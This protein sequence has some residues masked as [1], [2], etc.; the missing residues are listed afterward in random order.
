MGYEGGIIEI[1]ESCAVR[2][3][4]A[5]NPSTLRLIGD[6]DLNGRVADATQAFMV[7]G[8]SR[9]DDVVLILSNPKF[10]DMVDQAVSNAVAAKA[11][12][13]PVL[14]RTVCTPLATGRWG[15]RSYALYQRLEGFSGNGYLRGLQM[16]SAGP[17][18]FDWLSAAYWVTRTECWA[19][20]E[21]ERDFLVPLQRLA[22]DGD[23]DDMVRLSAARLEGLV[24]R[25]EVRTETCLQHGDFWFGNV[26]FYRAPIGALSQMYLEFQVIDWGGSRLRGYPGIDALR[27][28]LS[29]FGDGVLA[30]ERVR[31]F[32]KSIGFSKAEFSVS[33]F[34]GLGWLAGH[35]NEF[36][37][38]NFNGMARNLAGFLNRHG[39]LTGA[40][41]H[42]V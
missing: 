15:D 17:R 4:G 31:L 29:G 37:K 11:A 39:F 14:G 12:L 10:P 8:Y 35:L 21:R 41:G 30:A 26:M 1:V 28:A 7:D 6:P 27:F 42:G 3:G 23:L 32:T 36:P 5:V 24:R 22:E 16:L 33:C 9:R 13:G 40:K 19:G 20:K 38:E 34:C 18:I 2:Q 25:D